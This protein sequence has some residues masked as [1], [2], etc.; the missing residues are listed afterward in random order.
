MRSEAWF[1][2]K[3]L[4][5]LV[6]ALSFGVGM[7]FAQDGQSKKAGTGKKQ[8]NAESV[9]K[10]KDKDHD[11]KLS[12]EEFIGKVK[13]PEHVKLLEA[14]FKAMDADGDGHVTFEEFKAYMA[15][16]AQSTAGKQH[17][18]KHAHQAKSTLAT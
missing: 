15:K 4:A 2:W 7:T 16:H 18:K 10:A 5:V 8:Q 1:M 9:F 12:K 14:R 6:L 3:T 13:D 11:G 17:G